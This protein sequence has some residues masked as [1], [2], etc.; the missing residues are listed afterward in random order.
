MSNFAGFGS[1]FVGFGADAVSSPAVGGGKAKGRRRLV[2]IEDTF[3]YATDREIQRLLVNA[4][5]PESKQIIVA[6]PKKQAKQSAPE[7]EVA[8]VYIPQWRHEE[9]IA[10]RV[11]TALA[12]RLLDEADDEDV[13]VMLLH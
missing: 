3:Y 12:Q 1:N 11:D 5:Q 13:E 9:V 6:K 4:I 10:H 7:I 8:P 2:Q